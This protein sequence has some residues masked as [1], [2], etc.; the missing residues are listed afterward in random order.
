MPIGFIGG[1]GYPDEER[2]MREVT[3]AGTAAWILGLRDA[4]ACQPQSGNG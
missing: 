4:Q 2:G 3:L 1:I